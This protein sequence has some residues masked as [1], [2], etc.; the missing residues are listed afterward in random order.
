M[1][2]TLSGMDCLINFSN[3][4]SFGPTRS[5]ILFENFE[6]FNATLMHEHTSSIDI[7]CSKSYNIDIDISY[8]VGYNIGIDIGYD[9]G[10]NM[11]IDVDIGYDIGDP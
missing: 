1:V 5:I 2:F 11:N 4:I 9:I 3:E 10:Y 8:N 7:G 6:E